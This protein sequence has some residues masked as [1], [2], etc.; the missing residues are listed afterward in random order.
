VFLASSKVTVL[1]VMGIVSV[2][3]STSPT[4]R[5]GARDSVAANVH[6]AKVH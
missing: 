6:S 4:D 2:I 5:I 3:G 1:L